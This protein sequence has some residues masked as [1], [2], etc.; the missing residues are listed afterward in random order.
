MLLRQNCVRDRECEQCPFQSD[1]VVW[2]AFYT[3]MEQRP[4][5][6][7]GKESVGYLITCNDR[8]CHFQKGSHLQFSL[9]LFGSCIAFFGIYL[10][11][12]TYLGMVGLG[13]EQARFRIV[14]IQTHNERTIL[15][16]GMVDMNRL[17][18]DS[19]QAYVDRRMEQFQDWDGYLQVTF[20]TPLSMKYQGQ[21]LHRFDGTA[22]VQG[23]ARR[24]Q[25]LQYYVGQPQ[26]MQLIEYY[27]RVEAQRCSQTKASRHSTTQQNQM[28]MAGIIGSVRLGEVS[29]QC[30]ELLLAGELLHIG[31]NTSFGYGEYHIK[32]VAHADNFYE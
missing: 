15:E 27:P 31:K 24:L 16:N 2:D 1:C 18:T 14:H 8:C 26:E 28:K 25:M 17:P 4:G 13:K 19:V 11:A 7:T 6:V 12:F 20:K 21:F 5:Y 30:L 22:L 9:T 3:R 10:Q 32:P 23:A 29:S